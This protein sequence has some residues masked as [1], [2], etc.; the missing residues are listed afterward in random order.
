MRQM[1]NGVTFKLDKYCYCGELLEGKRSKYCSTSC[2]NSF[3]K[4]QERKHYHKTHPPLPKRICINCKKKY[5]PRTSRQ[6]CCSKVCRREIIAQRNAAKREANPKVKSSVHYKQFFVRQATYMGRKEI[7]KLSGKVTNI[8]SSDYQTEINKFLASGGKVKVLA[9]QLDGRV[10][11]VGSTNYL[12]ISKD[13]SGEDF[14]SSNGVDVSGDWDVQ[15]L[16]GFGY[17]LHIMDDK[18]DQ[19]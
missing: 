19:D 13:N 16:S 2:Y 1:V 8:T 17:E 5:R 12:R 6:E 7:K 9:D 14:A 10:P 4:I 18:S 11:G 3:R 15:T